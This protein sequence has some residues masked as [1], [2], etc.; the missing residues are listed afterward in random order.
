MLPVLDVYQFKKLYAVA[1]GP[2]SFRWAG[3]KTNYKITCD[4][5][6]GPADIRVVE[7]EIK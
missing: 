5:F 3:R 2:F 1:N 6:D 4:R 7:V